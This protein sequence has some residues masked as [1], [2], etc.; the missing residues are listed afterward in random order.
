M[1][2]V[3]TRDGLRT[4][5]TLRNTVDVP[6]EIGSVRLRSLTA[7][8]ALAFRTLV[9]THQAAGRDPEALAP[10]LIA[11]SWIGEDGELLFPEEEGA[12]IA[13]GLSPR[14]YGALAQA[15]LE[16][17]GMT[18]AAS[19]AAGKDSGASPSADT[20]TGSPENSATPTST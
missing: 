8:E 19:D 13:L 10:L 9:M 4:A 3:L 18:A 20:R 12:E 5:T 17:N 14:D 2:A 1:T 11:K 7:G 16:L 6:L 15:T